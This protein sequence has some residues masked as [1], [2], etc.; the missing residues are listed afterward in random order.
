MYTIE[1]EERETMKDINEEAEP[2]QSV[3]GERG[4][5]AKEALRSGHT[6]RRLWV[7]IAMLVAMALVVGG[8][9]GW[10]VHRSTRRGP[11]ARRLRMCC[12]WI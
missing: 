7:I 2:D 1:S 10:N 11:A 12:A 8:V 4:E 5:S 9:W 3:D 6:R